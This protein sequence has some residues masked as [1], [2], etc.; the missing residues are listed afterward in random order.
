VYL[1][2]PGAADDPDGFYDVTEGRGGG[3]TNSPL[4]VL[5]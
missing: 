3:Q 5:S 1:V 2:D 4:E